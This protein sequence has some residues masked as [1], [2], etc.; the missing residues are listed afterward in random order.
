[1]EFTGVGMV[2]Q[3]SFILDN[4]LYFYDGFAENNQIQPIGVLSKINLERLF[5]DN[6]Y[7]IGKIMGKNNNNYSYNNYNQ[8]ESPNKYEKKNKF[9]LNQ[10][11]VIGSRGVYNEN[12]DEDM[13]VNSSVFR[14]VS[15]EKL[16]DEKKRLIFNE[17]ENNLIQSKHIFNYELL[18]KFIEILLRAFKYFDNNK[19]N[20]IHKNLPFTSENILNLLNEVKHILESENT[21]IK[22]RS[23]R[24]II[25]KFIW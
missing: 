22:I 20:S 18:N 13:D 5:K 2:R 21:L 16:P 3:S 7:L 25:W 9:K 17:N 23:P 8:I 24:K 14:K 6:D 12:S 19:I 4:Y 11:V 10:D 15:I 1:L